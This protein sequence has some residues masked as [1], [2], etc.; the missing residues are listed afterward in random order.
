VEDAPRPP[1]TLRSFLQ[2]RD[3]RQR[4]TE[5]I[6]GSSSRRLAT[7]VTGFT[8]SP[9]GCVMAWT[10]CSD[11]VVGEFQTVGRLRRSTRPSNGGWKVVLVTN[12]K[13]GLLPDGL[14]TGRVPGWKSSNIDSPHCEPLERWTQKLHSVAPGQV[15]KHPQTE[16][17]AENPILCAII[18]HP[19][20]CR[21]ERKLR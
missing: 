4:D 14:P 9:F 21:E 12:F 17:F 19:I 2:S 8:K 1:V 18:S 6:I 16:R 20:F 5:A 15:N 10:D 3:D 13:I 7:K 11:A